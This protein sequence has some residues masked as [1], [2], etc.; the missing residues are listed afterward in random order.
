MKK[1]FKITYIPLLLGRKEIEEYFLRS[2]PKYN[3]PSTRRNTAKSV[4]E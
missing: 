4:D 1:H 3:S 2:M